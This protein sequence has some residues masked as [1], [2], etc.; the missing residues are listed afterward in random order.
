[1][2]RNH[3]LRSMLAA[4][5]LL[6]AGVVSHDSCAMAQ[7]STEASLLAVDAKGK[8]EGECP[9][10]HTE[11]K[12]EIT[13]FLARVI[14]TQHFENP[15]PDKIEAVYTFPLPQAA[16]VDDMSIV[17]GNRTVKGKIMRREEAQATYD[18]A[19]AQ[20]QVAALLNQQRPNIFTQAVAN[21]LPGQQIDVMISYVETLKYDEGSYEWSFPMVV[22]A[23]YIPGS[24]P[25]S[26][27]SPSAEQADAQPA[28][29]S[30]ERV[31]DASQITPPVMPKGRRAGHDISL[32]VTIDAGVPLIGFQSRTHEIEALQPGFG[33]AVVRLKDQATIP[34]KDFVL[35]YN[36]AGAKIE[37][38]L[39]THR[40]D[41]G[42]YF[43]FILQ[44]PARVTAPD[45]MP[46]ELVFVLDTS[47]SMSGFPI[48]KAKE[49]MK[50]ALDGLY[51]Q[52]TF[53]VILFSGDTKILFPS[54]MPATAEN[55]RKAKDLVAHAKGDGGTEMMKAIRAA[56]RPS[57]A[58]DHVR[59][60]CFMTDG[61]VGDDMAIISE[62]QKHPNAR[63][64]AMGFGSAPNRF[65]LDKITEYG[66]GEVEYVTEN[67][68]AAG[69]AERFHER[70]RNPLLTDVSIDWAGLPVTDI[71][72]KAI[73]DLFS[74]KPTIISGRY[75]A[76][77]KGVI[78]LKGMMAGREFVRE[79]P[80]ELPDQETQ[81]DVLATLWARRKVDDLMGQDMS[82]MQ[83]DKMKDKL[84]TEITNL[85]LAYRM[86]TQFTSFVAVED[87]TVTD[88]GEPRR[89]EVPVESTSGVVCP[90]GVPCATVNVTAG[91]SSTM[92]SSSSDVSVNVTSRSLQD[93]P[94]NGR[95]LQ[96]LC[97]ITPGTV[98]PAPGDPISN[99]R[100]D[101]SVNGQ[102]PASNQIIVDG[103][104]GNFGI[105][106]GGQRPGA[107]ASG[108]AAAL[109]ATGATSPLV[110]LS[111]TQEVEIRTYS[112]LAEYGR[113][114]GG[115]ISVV[116]KSGT[117]KFHGSSFYFFGNQRFDANDWFANSRGLQ[118]PRHGS[119]E[120]GGTLGGP[121]KRDQMF[122]FASYEGLR[123]Q[124]PVT[125]ISDVPSLA[126]RLSAPLNTQPLLNLY[127][128][129]N[130]PERTD[131]F[132][133][134]A[135]SFANRGRHDAESVR[136]DYAATRRLMLSGY[137][138]FA[139]SSANERGAG[140]FSLNTL[141]R[142]F[143]RSQ[144]LTG[145]ASYA[146]SPRVLVTIKANYSQFTSR[147]SYRLDDFGGAVLPAESLFSQ[148]SLSSLGA[149]FSAD[150]NGRNTILMSGADVASKQRQLNV[151]SSVNFVAG[152]HSYKVGADYRR[153][154][155]IIGLR[156][157]EQSTLFDGVLQTLT[158]S[159]AR[160]SLFARRQPQRPVF[161]NFS[162][163][164]QDEW[165]VTPNLTLTYGLRWELNPAPGAAD[166]NN[167]LAV[168]DVND[169]SRL[170]L[171]PG[172]RLWATT[173][174][175]FAPRVG[176]AYQTSNGKLVIRGGFGVLYD[177]ANA[178]AGDAFA[179][180]YPFLNGTS[181]LNAPF[182]FSVASLPSGATI[183]VPFYA[184]DPRLKAP[185]SL[186]WNASVQREIGSNQFVSAAYLGA[187]DR[188][189]LLTS[190]VL[191]PTANLSFVRLTNNGAKSDYHSLQLQFNR[192]FSRRL[193]AII[194]YTWAKSLDNSSE[195]SAARALFRS[196]DS[197][198]ERGPSDFDIRHT[199]AGFLSYD[200]PD[201]FASG[202][203]K[204]LFHNWSVDSVF[205]VRSTSPVNVV[206]GIP[207]SFGFIY[208]R[209]DAIGG[210]PLYLND[211]TVAG[212]RRIN[213]SA[214]VVPSDFRQG[215]LG[216]NALRGFPLTQFNLALRRQFKFSED[217]KL[218]IGIQ[219]T[220]V[221]NNPNFA[222]PRGNDA[223][224][225]TRFDAANPF[226]A[227]P[228]FGQSLTNAAGGSWGSAGSSF[229][230]S[231]YP[232]G[233][234]SLQLSAKLIF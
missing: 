98:A 11:V 127:P 115:V 24:E 105:A 231:Y 12:T 214:F 26:E 153:M 50:L 48:E 10:K 19:R 46:K 151:L 34:N 45:V 54:P 136:I 179:E 206:Y 18:A 233:S 96:S 150:L 218:I 102:R 55:L 184:F 75:S 14:V 168:N 134:F 201:P 44:P 52:D 33:R 77:G 182:S 120:F 6:V 189:L 180:S 37:D 112:N 62:V 20:G 63:V 118:R 156:Q 212:G 91:S 80:V 64:F 172:A 36:V 56:L 97:L 152:T 219:V 170:S 66:R 176:V 133:E 29:A 159:A 51:P 209:P 90:S 228:T 4:A 217:V 188:R 47:G 216:R 141:N 161:D 194:S 225:G 226:H 224:L 154:F 221:F 35:K 229:G 215:T 202:F 111:A 40:D 59:I 178:A 85:G 165:R 25:T 191:N 67:G 195:D 232:G 185:Y 53:N 130:R 39:L 177:T 121:I 76:G 128:L 60:T 205:N 181:V 89:I 125:S 92:N 166:G 117:N 82:G 113:N 78:R 146:M 157:R 119:N 207:T 106:P 222:A 208:L 171:A 103:A 167:A 28:T 220:N 139:D 69:A 84:K 197:Q 199:L 122:F 124:Q 21:I 173:Y 140:G 155:P 142:I 49:T 227:N 126:A 192:R 32:E 57:D 7:S 30:N 74:A 65:L 83:A 174:G 203:K 13:G 198:I 58:Q 88:G 148:S 158:G 109:T 104:S 71:Y 94:L 79:I 196:G 149:S 95:N 15:F 43:T 160:V 123:L 17:V 187:A 135:S 210:V 234:R 9:L 193:G 164:A 42:G 41:R 230:S 8:P 183:S 100:L 213:P 93:L 223:S 68:D 108:N 129:P 116:T 200:L 137:Y 101:V 132:A 143:N 190:T 147:S 131:G 1:M 87:N 163:Y 31:P 2:K 81:H 144:A 73:P 107:S 5:C 211:Q 61:Q 22:G 186:Q 169:P 16:A 70:V 175:N 23:R 3:L 27:A 145:T 204:A 114:T 99:V 110:P 72:P 138:D 38:A 162:A 86:M